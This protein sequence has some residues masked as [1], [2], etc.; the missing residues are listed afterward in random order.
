MIE[1]VDGQGVSFV[2]FRLL[3]L[4]DDSDGEGNT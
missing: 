3:P 4:L 1:N 2:D